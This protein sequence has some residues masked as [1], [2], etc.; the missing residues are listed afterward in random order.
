MYNFTPRD[1]LARNDR[2]RRNAGDFTARW[3]CTTGDYDYYSFNPA[4]GVAWEPIENLTTYGNISRGARTPSVIELGCA[5]DHTLDGQP[6]NSTN[7][8][9]GCSIPTAL[10]ADP[11]LK[12]VRSTS[13][14]AG[15]R[16]SHGGFDWNIGLFRTELKD[17]ILFVPLG[18]KNRGVFDNFGQTRRQG[19]EMG[20]KGEIGSSRISL[21]YTFMRAT[22]ESPAQ[23]I[24]DANSSNTAPTTLQSYVNI[25][26]GDELPGMPRHVL[27]ANWNYQFND[28]FDI[29]LNT[30]THSS[31]YVRGN[32]N[33]DHLARVA[34]HLG[35]G[36]DRDPYD[37]IGSGKIAG[38]TVL[39]LRANYRF[40]HG[41]TL[42]AKVDNLLNKKY[43][44]AG[45][46]G[47]NPFTQPEVFKVIPVHGPIPPLSDRVRPWRSG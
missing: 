2:C 42:F 33:N 10:S 28:R 37:Y 44:T 5:R 21:N 1:F 40:D 23:I 36:I 22:F 9:F 27:Q 24:N 15:V 39:N 31:S 25:Q 8:Q 26:P 13:Y 19:V 41:I 16:G 12:Q 29:T 11:Y 3:I 35:A 43:A 30:I 4:F 20:A 18:R 14:E 7:Y 32:E 34:S 6:L 38:Y 17:D 47:R 46:L 45:D